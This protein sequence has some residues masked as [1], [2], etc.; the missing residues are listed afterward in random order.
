MSSSLTCRR[1]ACDVPAHNY[2]WS[3]EP[4]YDWSA[5]YASSS[6][7]FRYF[8]DFATKYNLNQYIRTSRQVTGAKW[9]ADRGGYDVQVTNFATGKIEADYCDILINASGVLNAWK[10]PTIPGLEKYQGALLH[11]ANWDESVELEGKHVGLIGNGYIFQASSKSNTKTF[12]SSGIQIL[13]AIHPKVSKLTTFIRGP[14]WISTVTG[15]KQHL[16]SKQEQEDFLGKPGALTKYRKANEDSHNA[17]WPT[18]LR[19]S[20]VQADSKAA[21]VSQM[22]RNLNNTYLEEKLI[23]N[24]SVGCRR[25]TPGI[26]YLETLSANNVDVVFGEITEVTEIGCKCSNGKEY[27]VD[28]LIC[29]TGFDVSFRPRFPI[30]GPGP[31]ATNLQDEWAMEAKG[32]LGLAAAAFPNYMMFLGPNCPVGNGPLLIAIGEYIFALT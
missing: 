20:Q 10:W 32:Y 4:K 26:N 6:E 13:P 31:A 24:W 12:R 25:I 5:V 19:G 15:L 18:F 23:P 16:Y 21:I 3:F 14:T 30:I 28:V 27:D 9:N 8:N 17:A 1:C 11:S 2:T 22:K 7:I 29:A